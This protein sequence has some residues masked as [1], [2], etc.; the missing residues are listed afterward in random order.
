MIVFDG[1]NTSTDQFSSV[2]S[3][4][5]CVPGTSSFTA[6]RKMAAES[7]LLLLKTHP[8]SVHQGTS[9]ASF[10]QEAPCSSL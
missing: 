10:E 1:S 2:L 3:M 5:L 8:L 9:S 7:D 6:G 4:G